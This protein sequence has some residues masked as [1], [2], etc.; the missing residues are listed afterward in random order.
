MD[1]RRVD[2]YDAPMAART[3]TISTVGLTSVL[4]L[5]A[6]QSSP[7]VS[8][9][10]GAGGSAG[11]AGAAD[12]AWGPADREDDYYP[13]P[14]AG[15]LAPTPPMGWNSWNQFHCNINQELIR[16][17]ADAMVSS[18]MADAGYE[19]LNIDDCWLE[20]ERDDEGRLQP[21][22]AFSDG[23]AALA[24]YVHGLGLK[25]GIYGDRG[26]ETCAHRAGSEGSEA[27][28]ADTL[29]A[30]GIDYLKYDNCCTPADTCYGGSEIYQPAY[31][32]MASELRRAGRETG[33]KI[34][35][36]ICAWQFYEWA[37]DPGHLWRT[38]SDI[39]ATFD[40]VMA[41]LDIN[42]A[43]AAY[44]EPNSWNDP[45][46]MEVGVSGGT[47]T[48]S[49]DEYRAHFSM[50]AMM[51]APLIAGNDLRDMD[52]TTVE[53][54]TNEEI[55]AVNQDALGLQGVPVWQEGELSVWAKPLNEAGAVAVALLNRS[56]T[57]AK[58]T[59]RFADVGLWEGPAE[60][61]DLWAHEDLGTFTGQF[62]TRV[63]SHAAVV[64]KI[65]GVGPSLPRGAT[66]LSDLTWI[67][68]ANALGP[69][70][71]DTDVGASRAGDGDPISLGGADYAKGLGVGAG[72]KIIFRLG[73]RCSRFLADFGLTDLAA[74]QGGSVEYQVLGDDGV[75]AASD[76]V[77]TGDSGLQ[78][79]DVDVS[80]QH[81]LVLKVTNGFDG[82]G[83][84]RAVWADARLECDD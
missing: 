70:E 51:A 27:L 13:V 73:Q 62:T 81:R 53:I 36:S 74:E 77:I 46:M 21:S 26:N 78:P 29:A 23:I 39:E 60:V 75:L 25:L 56:D 2:A 59:A 35:F 9:H 72:S 34:V 15:G 44:A 79:I 76:G 8:R 18:G 14:L 58:M 64:V 41:N 40:S 66:Y 65:T 42:R 6:C 83:W 12:P 68:A 7:I 24:D 43:Y 17:T 54:L 48:M 47:R 5:A 30:W 82:P 33:Q 16:E 31:E 32:L 3:G 57:A 45:D 10:A 71:R 11:A 22:E 38:T 20:T 63:P 84:D 28:D 50:W 67:Y 1:T 52:T 19:Y 4:M 55:I 49:D 80:G 37:V 69:V 61:R